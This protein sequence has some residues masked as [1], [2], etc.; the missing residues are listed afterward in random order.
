MLTPDVQR[1]FIDSY[2]LRILLRILSSNDPF[3]PTFSGWCVQQ[4]SK[5][6]NIVEKTVPMYLPPINA[7]VT[8][9]STRDKVFET[10]QRH[11][12]KAH[13]PYA[14][15]TLDVGAAMNA[16]KLLW[17]YPEKYKNVIIHLGD[18]HFFERRVY[19]AWEVDIKFRIRR[20]YFRQEYAQLEAKIEY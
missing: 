15:L 6:I 4:Q 1:V 17:N 13:M 12:E 20:S 7:P 2:H 19:N 14:N 16:Y 10:L 8:S 3:A 5:K 9:F 11:P 18:F